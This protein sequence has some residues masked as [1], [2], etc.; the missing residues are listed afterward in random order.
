MKVSFDTMPPVLLHQ[1]IPG[2]SPTIVIATSILY[3]V[4]GKIG[5]T[6]SDVPGVLPSLAVG[7]PPASLSQ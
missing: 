6:S 3:K 1:Y 4:S 2:I 5:V 7:V